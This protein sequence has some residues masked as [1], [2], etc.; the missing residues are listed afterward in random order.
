MR[1]QNLLTL[2]GHQDHVDIEI[3][4]GVQLSIFIGYEIPL[5]DRVLHRGVDDR[6]VG[7]FQD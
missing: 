3:V 6:C 2:L 4:I 5:V 7:Q 1:C